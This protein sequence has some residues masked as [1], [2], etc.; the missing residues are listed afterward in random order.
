MES[1]VSTESTESVNSFESMRFAVGHRLVPAVQQ[2]LSYL[3]IAH[4]MRML[5]GVIN[6]VFDGSHRINGLPTESILL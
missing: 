4:S 1:V 2:A 5:L 3:L 6:R